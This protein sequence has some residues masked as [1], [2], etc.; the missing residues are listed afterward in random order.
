MKKVLI[1]TAIAGAALVTYFRLKE[2]TKMCYN[3]VGLKLNDIGKTTN[4]VTTIEVKNKGNVNFKL[5]RIELD[6]FAN[7]KFIGKIFSTYDIAMPP[8]SAQ[9][10]ELVIGA[11]T[12]DLIKDATSMLFSKGLGKTPIT[13][14]G[15]IV[16]QTGIIKF[17][18]PMVETTSVSKLVDYYLKPSTESC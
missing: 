16:I 5:K 14:N 3:F 11:N 7:D 4:I 18:Y 13:F 15:T 6:I 1:F 9:L 8:N 12:R 2:I 10:V 17:S